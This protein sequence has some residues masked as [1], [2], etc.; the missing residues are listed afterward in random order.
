[1]N[2]DFG[3]NVIIV[4]EGN[5]VLVS[6]KDESK[7]ARSLWGAVRMHIANMIDGLTKGT[8]TRLQVEG[9]GYRAAV[10]GKNLVLNVGFTH[11]VIIEAPA[12]ITYKV[13]KNIVSVMGC[14]KELVTKLAA[15]IRRVR[16]PEPYK[17]KGFVMSGEIVRKKVGKKAAA[18]K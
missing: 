1:L 16:P 15:Q 9:I 17:G 8:E 10:D 18:A 5:E 3:P 13:E 2:R 7:Q 6:A 14:D 4:K 11:P 12:G